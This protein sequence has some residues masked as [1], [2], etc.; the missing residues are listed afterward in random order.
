MKLTSP[1]SPN[2]VPLRPRPKGKSSEDRLLEQILEAERERRCRI[3]DQFNNLENILSSK[4]DYSHVYS[5]KL[6]L[7]VPIPFDFETDRRF[8][9]REYCR[10]SGDSTEFNQRATVQLQPQLTLP[11]S[12]N[13]IPLRSRPIGKPSEDRILEEA[14]NKESERRERLDLKARS[15]QR[16]LEPKEVNLR[17]SSHNLTLFEPFEFETNKRL[18]EKTLPKPTPKGIGQEN[19]T[20]ATTTF[21]LTMPQPF[22]FSTRFSQ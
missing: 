4:S 17:P 9:P 16:V 8:G 14:L 18:G 12:P 20:P 2:F 19:M 13:F 15:M 5:E 22:R 10:V 11:K 1:H 6:P 21:N 7:T 3:M